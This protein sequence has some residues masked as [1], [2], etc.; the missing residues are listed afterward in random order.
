MDKITLI[1]FLI[2]WSL[3]LKITLTTYLIKPI[4]IKCSNPTTTWLIHGHACI[5]HFCWSE[6]RWAGHIMWGIWI[7]SMEVGPH[8][9]NR[10]SQWSWRQ[11]W[12]ITCSTEHPSNILC[13][14]RNVTEKTKP[15]LY[16]QQNSILFVFTQNKTPFYSASICRMSSRTALLMLLLKTWVLK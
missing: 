13:G 5:D 10:W 14:S 11:E 4:H 9:S 1:V 2:K 7:R 12:L 8:L 15:P 16:F 3:L 6:I